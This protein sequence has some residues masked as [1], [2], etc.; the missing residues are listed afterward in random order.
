[1]RVLIRLTA[2]VKQFTSGKGLWS[3]IFT[4][5]AFDKGMTSSRRQNRYYFTHLHPF[6]NLVRD[7]KHG[8]EE[9]PI[10]DDLKMSK[11]SYHL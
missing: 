7:P 8:N 1:M 4:T 5:E 2:P 3:Y 11:I 10:S 6:P 9:V